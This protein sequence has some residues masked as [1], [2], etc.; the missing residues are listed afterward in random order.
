MTQNEGLSVMLLVGDATPVGGVWAW[1]WIMTKLILGT[2]VVL[3]KLGRVLNRCGFWVEV[4][5]LAYIGVERM[6]VESV[7]SVCF[8]YC[9]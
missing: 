9:F 6:R 2:S 7:P 1:F 4:L 8:I 3:N 5:S